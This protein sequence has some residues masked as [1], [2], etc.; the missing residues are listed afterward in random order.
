M[1][2]PASSPKP[3]Q[4]PP[5]LAVI[6][7]DGTPFPLLKT[8]TDGGYCPNLAALLVTGDCK[9]THSSRPP[10][11]SVAWTSFATACNP[12]RHGIF[13]F[14]D[15]RP[16][17]L[18]TFIP[19]TADRK[20]PPWWEPISR[21]GGRVLVLNCPGNYPPQP[22]NGLLIAGFEAPNLEKATFPAS[23]LPR[24]E[25]WGYIVDADVHLGHQDRAA[26][27]RQLTQVID[28]RF[29]A[30]LGLLDAEPWDAVLCVC[31][32]TDLLH[33]FFWAD[34]EA[35][36]GWGFDYFLETYRQIDRYIGQTLER[37]DAGTELALLADHG[38]C[39]LH[40][41]VYVN[42]WLREQ[43]WFVAGPRHNPGTL[44]PAAGTRAY[45]LAGGRVYVNLRGREATGEVPSTEYET[46]MEQL[47]GALAAWTHPER[48]ETI[49]AGVR[50][51]AEAY[52]GP[53]AHLAADLL[54][55]WQR[56]YDLR[57][58][59]PSGQV[60]AQ[61]AFSGMHSVDDAFL[62]VRRRRLR[63]GLIMLHDVGATVAAL[64]GV[65]LPGADGR[66]ALA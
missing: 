55:D 6:G 14:I 46:V 2:A 7:L 40:A 20:A 42:D 13:G 21:A 10:L 23:Y 9:Q 63:D 35:Q 8:L 58:T 52:E 1:S 50:R 60:F 65:T 61:G 66:S 31:K 43:G 4:R 26:F 41:E 11:S 36:S 33:H 18:E 5:R 45:A 22:V 32:E 54:P 57:G 53:Y 38:F 34:W 49:F 37:F 56:G 30:F 62:Y 29:R 3:R 64:A 12:G 48:G 19:T 44:D 39:R 25:E 24:L 17:P 15:R 28:G 16:N 47:G 27:A 51:G 59:H